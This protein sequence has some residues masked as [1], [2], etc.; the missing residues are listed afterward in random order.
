MR[1]PD[2]LKTSL[3]FLLPLVAMMLI[4]SPSSKAQALGSGI[5]ATDGIGAI[6]QNK[7]T[8]QG[9]PVLINGCWAGSVS[10]SGVGSDGIATVK[11]AQN[12]DKLLRLASSIDM[13]YAGAAFYA[14]FV[15]NVSSNGV[16]FRSVTG[17][18]DFARPCT[19]RGAV[20]AD[21]G[22]TRLM[23][24]FRLQGKCTQGAGPLEGTFDLVPCQ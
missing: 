10:I 13:D 20:T 14:Y 3:G 24:T 4:P 6:A 8:S 12:G 18:D 9:T 21:A 7:R 1:R 23:G 15:G 2:H 16:T 11:F 19:M 17:R 22:V 5:P